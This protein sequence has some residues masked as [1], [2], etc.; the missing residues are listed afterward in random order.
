MERTN[1]GE[2]VRNSKSR[3][4]QVQGPRLEIFNDPSEEFFSFPFKSEYGADPVCENS[5]KY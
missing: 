4:P 3:D 5:V 1:S 2:H